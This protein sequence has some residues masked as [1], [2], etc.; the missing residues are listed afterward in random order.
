MDTDLL[1]AW[2]G[3][4]QGAWPPDDRA[5]LSL[6]PGPVRP[7]DAERRALALM[8][9]LRPHQLLHPDLVTEGMNRLAQAMLA[10]TSTR[11][12]TPTTPHLPMPPQ[13]YDTIDLAPPPRLQLMPTT[14]PPPRPEPEVLDAEI[15]E[16]EE[17]WDAADPEIRFVSIEGPATPAAAE[18]PAAEVIAVPSVEPPTLV[19]PAGLSHESRR[20]VYR[21]L[22]AIRGLLK[23]WD[24]LRPYCGNPSERIDTPGRVYGALEGVARFQ[25]ALW[26]DGFDLPETA[27]LAPRMVAVF[28]QPL[29]FALLRML[30][31]PQRREL[32]RDWALGKARLEALQIAT[33][34]SLR[35]SAPGGT[36]GRRWDG[37][38][39]HLA[40]N[41]EWLLICAL[42]LL[43]LLAVSKSLL[44]P[45][46]VSVF[47]QESAKFL[48][49]A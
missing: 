48:G 28:R 27:R 26:H 17:D 22:V 24:A 5:L 16:P 37:L 29:A 35:A 44:R 30:I 31:L 47:V 45:V 32:A 46:G 41:P 36:I 6:P 11:E 3:L 42:A 13:G 19:L 4:P 38:R 49:P 14:A 21:R 34:N 39:N 25:E 20:P 23:A 8:G 10:V 43:A 12:V 9:K 1:R 7:A 15:V 40:R 18:D 2:L 33:R